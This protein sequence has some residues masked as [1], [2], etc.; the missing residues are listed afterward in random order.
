M[1]L[2]EVN[3]SPGFKGPRRVWGSPKLESFF[4][5]ILK[6]TLD[7]KLN[8]YKQPRADA[9]Q[10]NFVEIL[11]HTSAEKADRIMNG[12]NIRQKYLKYKMKY[13]KLR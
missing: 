9:D 3:T 12:G 1:K 5:D 13:L 7:K 6:L 4:D 11:N 10:T 2:L 8:V